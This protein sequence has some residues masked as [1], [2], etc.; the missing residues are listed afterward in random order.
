MFHTILI[1][2]DGSEYAENAALLASEIAKR[3]ASQIVVL[4][5]F[6]LSFAAAGD[7]GYGA[8]SVAPQILEECIQGELAAA[9][10]AVKPIL[11]PL[12]PPYRMLQELGHPVDAIIAVA[13]REKA[14]LIVVGSR[15][16][17]RLEELFLGSVS[18]GVLHYAHC[19][20]LIE[21]GD[22]RPMRRILLASDGSAGSSKAAEAACAL[23]RGFEA[24]LNVLNVNAPAGRFHKSAAGLHPAQTPE[25][26]EES[27][28]RHHSVEASVEAAAK[29]TGIAFQISEERGHVG[30]SIVRYADAENCDLIVMGSRGLGGFE[31]LLVGSVSNYVA[32]HAHCPVLIVR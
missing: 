24:C 18:S 5:V 3:F 22:P 19:P 6:D 11:A 10:K 17:S 23:A 28:R 9:E 27:E 12:Q 1:G 30:E 2:S 21:R 32:H 7:A 26:V 4:N 29:E 25:E 20:V 13:G 15:G 16:R 8:M 14:D 31:R